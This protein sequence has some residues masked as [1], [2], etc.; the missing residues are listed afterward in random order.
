MNSLNI[1]IAIYCAGFAYYAIKYLILLYRLVQ[2]EKMELD[3][4]PRT[5]NDILKS[6]LKPLR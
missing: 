6:G 4:S 1:I 2:V 5:A 3:V